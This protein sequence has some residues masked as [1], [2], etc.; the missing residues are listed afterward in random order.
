MLTGQELPRARWKSGVSLVS[1]YLGDAL[2]RLY[3]EKH[4]PSRARA[5]VAAIVSAI[6]KAH[7][8]TLEEAGWLSRATR[9]EAQRKL[10]AL[11]IKIGHPDTWRDYH[12]LEIRRDDL[13]GNV[14]RAL[15]FDN[16]FRTKRIGAPM[17][18]G[19][20]IVAP[21]TVNAY[22]NP[23][24]NEI[25]LPAAFLQ[26]P[27]FTVDADDAVNYGALGAAVG[28]EI[29]HGFDGPGRAVRRVRPIA[30]L[31]EGRGRAR[32]RRAHPRDC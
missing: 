12:G 25:V 24:L 32:V 8:D 3:V 28:H 22:Y 18:R 1:G 4:F 16:E 14:L 7:R 17:D 26:P 19:E 30:R 13:M 5:R 6:V 21:Q 9:I 10:S 29:G 27:I 31:V 23:A 15:R 2:G 11:A 20:W